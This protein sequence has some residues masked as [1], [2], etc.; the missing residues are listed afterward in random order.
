MIKIK[1]N[2]WTY[3]LLFFVLCRM[4][5]LMVSS[6]GDF[7]EFES[8]KTIATQEAPK[9]R[10]KFNRFSF[11]SVLFDRLGFTKMQKLYVVIAM[12]IILGVMG[13]RPGRNRRRGA[14]MKAPGAKKKQSKKKKKRKEK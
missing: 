12:I 14:A 13:V 1:V 3:Q 2:R 7:D 8:E 4:F 10:R 5:I 9:K 11:L 6:S